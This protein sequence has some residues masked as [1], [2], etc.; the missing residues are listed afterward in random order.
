M[1]AAIQELEDQ[2][3]P[4]EVNV[5]SAQRNPKRC[6]EYALGAESRGLKVIIAGP[7]RPRPWPV[8]LLP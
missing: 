3:I 2:G 7:A 4:C 6:G 1:D 5:L 8:S